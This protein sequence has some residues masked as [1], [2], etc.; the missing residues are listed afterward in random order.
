M[1]FEAYVKAL[2]QG[3]E[4]EARAF[5]NEEEIQR[6]QVYDWQWSSLTFRKVNPQHIDY[7]IMSAEDKGNHVILEVEWYYREAKAG[8]L[9]KDHRYFIRQNGEMVGANPILV[10]T[11]N[12]LQKE[13]EHFVYHY[14]TREDEPAPELLNGMD[15][16]YRNVVRLLYLDYARRIHYYKCDSVSEVGR[17]FDAEGSLARSRPGSRVVVSVRE[18]APHEVVHVISHGLFPPGQQGTPPEYLNEGLAYYLGGAT[19]FS[20]KLLLSWAKQRFERYGPVSFDSL[21]RNPWT[22]GANQGAGLVASFVKFLIDT[23][24]VVTLKQLFSAGED[25]DRQEEVLMRVFPRGLEEAGQEWEKFATGTPVPEIR[26]D[27]PIN[28]RKICYLQDVA[29]DDKGDGDYVYPLNHRAVSGIFDLIGFKLSLDDEMVY[30]QLYFSNLSHT[31]ISSDKGFNGT[32]AA[33]AIDK[34]QKSGNTRLFFDNGKVEFAEREGYEFAIEVSNAGV[35]VYDHDWMWQAMYLR[36]NSFQSHVKENEIYFA[37]PREIIGAPDS[38]WKIQVLTGGQTAGYQDVR[39]GV[40]R[41]MKVGAAS[42]TDQGGGGTE[43][44]FSP[45]VYDILTPEGQDQPQ[46]LGSYDTAKEKRAIIPMVRLGG[47]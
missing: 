35:L 17:L 19:F 14:K 9:Q 15:R 8:P 27:E 24:G 11:R 2:R 12:W 30:F 5:W 32:F 16:F 47:K 21:I 6:Y 33:I 40:G 4:Q 26:I 46:I 22:C 3:S 36:V 31:E 44:F 1:C 10:L 37:V 29:G 18:S 20:T 23:R 39:Y 25:F 45:D 28:C 42:S 38:S 41:F 7:R 43:T 13:S 34:D